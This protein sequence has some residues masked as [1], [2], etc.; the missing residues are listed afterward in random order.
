[1]LSLFS[2]CR[3]EFAVVMFDFYLCDRTNF[4]GY[5][6]KVLVNE[7]ASLNSNVSGMPDSNMVIPVS[8]VFDIR[9]TPL[10]IF[11][12]I[13]LFHPIRLSS[14]LIIYFDADLYFFKTPYLTSKFK[15]AT[16]DHRCLIT[17][18]N[19]VLLFCYFFKI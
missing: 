4:F 9:F 18:S 12:F 14:R 6:K 19:L 13:Q 7:I 11:Y 17:C 5:S 15:E 8:D 10:V 16:L 1:M 2:F 3:W